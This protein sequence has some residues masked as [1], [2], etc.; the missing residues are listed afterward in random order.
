MFE[1]KD[2]IN[3]ALHRYYFQMNRIVFFLLFFPVFVLGQSS[4]DEVELLFKQKKFSKAENIINTYLKENPNDEKAIELLGD[5]YGHQKRWDD[6]IET[7]KSL[8]DK[9]P[10]NANYHYKYGGS[11]G[12]KVLSISKIRAVGYIGDIREAFEKA[13]ELDPNHIDVR[14]ALVEFNI[15][16]PAILGGTEKKALKYAN[17]LEELSM[18][19]GYLSKGYIAEYS[20]RPEDAER[21][22]KQAIDIG[23]SVTC[24]QKLTD[25]YEKTAKQPEKAI[26]NIEK[27]QVKHKRNG[28]HYQ[29]GKVAAEYNIQ[30]D[31][32]EHCLKVYLEN[33]TA[34]DGVPKPWVYYRLAQIYKHRK[35][36]QEATKWIDKAI[37]GLPKIKTFKKEK[38]Q[39][40][41]L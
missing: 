21:Y 11:L 28:L 20:D 6:A 15:S 26:A 34:V 40:L 27:A 7:Y 1:N 35:N 9:E 29:I 16:V 18:V 19:D 32:G 5:A 23:G 22:Y 10:N 17:Q 30:L 12:M 4:I 24:Y 41:S 38:E 2:K 14:W 25:F 13:A 36:K 8:R 33:Y 31:K 3:L 39:I 37:V